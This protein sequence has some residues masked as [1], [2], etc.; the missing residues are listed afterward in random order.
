MIYHTLLCFDYG[1]K[2][3][4]VAVGQSITHTANPL[5]IVA[6]KNS[7]PDWPHI[8]KLIREWQPDALVV[9]IPVSTDG[10][11]DEMEQM[12]KK[13]IRQLQGRYNLPVHTVDESWSTYEARNRSPGKLDRV[14]HLAAQAILETWFDEYNRKINHLKDI[15][16]SH[17]RS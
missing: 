12:A 10:S 17:E 4:G 6:V 2:H 14:D 11:T 13:F 3:I 16:A 1:T 5:E 15:R 9:G 7:K 8:D